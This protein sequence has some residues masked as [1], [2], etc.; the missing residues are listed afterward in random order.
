[1]HVTFSAEPRCAVQ[2]RVYEITG[3]VGRDGS[4]ELVAQFCR[5]GDWSPSIPIMK[6]DVWQPW[7]DYSCCIY[8][9]QL[10]AK[11]DTLGF[12]GRIAFYILNSQQRC[13]GIWKELVDYNI[14]RKLRM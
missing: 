14:K 10:S 6:E 5:I 8:T 2:S 7:L 9:S 11:P 13:M 1:M 4:K 12:S 3:V